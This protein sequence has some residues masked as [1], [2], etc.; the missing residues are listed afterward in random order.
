MLRR[1]VFG[2]LDRDSYKLSHLQRSSLAYHLPLGSVVTALDDAQLGMQKF[3][4]ESFWKDYLSGGGTELRTVERGWCTD[5]SAILGM[6][7]LL[8]K[9]C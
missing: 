2:S 7:R 9:T 4:P 6:D 5:V 3:G 1:S 8:W